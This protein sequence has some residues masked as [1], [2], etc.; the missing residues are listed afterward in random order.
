MPGS[1]W[2]SILQ[3]CVSGQNGDPIGLHRLISPFRSFMGYSNGHWK[4]VAGSGSGVG[5]P[6]TT[7]VKIV[8]NVNRTND[9]LTGVNSFQTECW[10]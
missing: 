9:I 7:V 8:T 10:N 4:G 3:K 1:C 2:L 6:K 5:S